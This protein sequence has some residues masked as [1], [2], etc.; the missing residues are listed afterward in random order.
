MHIREPARERRLGQEEKHPWPAAGKSHSWSQTGQFGYNHVTEGE[1]CKQKGRGVQGRQRNWGIKPL[2]YPKVVK[3]RQLWCMFS[4]SS[5]A[6]ASGGRPRDSSALGT[7]GSVPPTFERLQGPVSR[8]TVR[9]NP[10]V[11][12]VR[13]SLLRNKLKTIATIVSCK[14]K[15]DALA[16]ELRVLAERQIDNSVQITPKLFLIAIKTPTKTMKKIVQ[17]SSAARQQCYSST[18][19]F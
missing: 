17:Q 10:V 5:P 19:L 11:V 4:Y 16:T 7:G 13:S 3:W 15:L 2:V 8:C 18:C 14:C 6:T 9:A 1:G 12:T